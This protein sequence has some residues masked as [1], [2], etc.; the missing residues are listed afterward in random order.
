MTVLSSQLRQPGAGIEVNDDFE[1][2]NTLY[3]ERGWTDG[4]PIVPQG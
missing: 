3:L 2:I 4:L 1:E